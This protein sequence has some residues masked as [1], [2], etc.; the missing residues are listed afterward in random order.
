ME[1]SEIF[2]MQSDLNNYVY[3]KHSITDNEGNRL[4]T[5]KLITAGSEEG[6]VMCNSITN[7][8]LKKQSWALGDEVRELNE[9]LMDK[10]WSK[11]PLDMQN[12]RVELID[13]LHF[14]VSGMMTA[15]MSASDVERI[16]KQKW[17]KNFDRQDNGYN[18]AEKTEDDNQS[19]K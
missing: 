9:E 11:D 10:W 1:L 18:A 12:I 17:Q 19:I 15:G 6:S 5:D 8:W 4:T 3:E 13:I 7:E 2:K 16:Y 14:L